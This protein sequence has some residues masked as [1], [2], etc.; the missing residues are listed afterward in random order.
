MKTIIGTAA[1]SVFFVS[2]FMAP[3]E[4]EQNQRVQAKAEARMK[5][6]LFTKYPDPELAQMA[7][8]AQRKED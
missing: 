4:Q 7:V 6:R 5:A 3:I 1:L 2:A 8:P